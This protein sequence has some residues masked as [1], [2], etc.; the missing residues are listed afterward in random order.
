VV[1][2]TAEFFDQEPQQFRVVIDDQQPVRLRAQMLDA[3]LSG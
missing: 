3:T 1:A 2:G